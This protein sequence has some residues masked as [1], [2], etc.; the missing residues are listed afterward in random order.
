MYSGVK[1]DMVADMSTKIRPCDR[2]GQIGAHGL[3]E[4]PHGTIDNSV[5]YSLVSLVSA[6]PVRTD[7]PQANSIESTRENPQLRPRADTTVHDILFLIR[8]APHCAQAPA[9]H[10]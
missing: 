5:P 2:D 3:S 1:A 10:P 8:Y 4:T 6:L 7:C 9:S